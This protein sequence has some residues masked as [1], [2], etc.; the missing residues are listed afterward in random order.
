MTEQHVVIV[1]DDSPHVVETPGGQGPGGP[2][3]DPG[4]PTEIRVTA[5][6]IQWRVEGDEDWIDLIALADIEGPQGEKGD[7]GDP[8][9]GLEV[10]VDGDQIGVRVEGDAE[11]IYTDPLTGPAGTTDYDDLTN[12]PSEFPPEAHGHTIADVTNL[13]SELD[14]KA[15]TGHGHTLSDISDSGDLAPR[16]RASV[17]QHR[18]LSGD[19]GLTAARLGDAADIVDL[20]SGGSLAPN[21]S[22]FITAQYTV[23]VAGSTFT[24]NNPTNV[25]PGTVRVIYLERSFSGEKSASWGSAYTGP[26]GAPPEIDITPSRL[27]RLI[28][29]PTPGGAIMVTASEYEP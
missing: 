8:G 16:N 18:S 20:G 2:P 17:A 23:S 9:P 3:G 29:E 19:V 6:H 28:L 7:Q 10:D 24:I 11:Y 22:S 21:W 12:V 25:I 4:E 26:D 14:G 1:T 27:W 5:T 13:Q 15:A